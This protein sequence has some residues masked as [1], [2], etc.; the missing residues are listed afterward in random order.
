MFLA[1]LLINTFPHTVRKQESVHK[2][3]CCLISNEILNLIN[4]EC[5]DISTLT[6]VNL[7]AIICVW[8]TNRIFKL[9]FVLK[10]S[11]VMLSMG[12]GLLNVFRMVVHYH[13]GKY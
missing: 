9:L 5:K 11:V 6:P 12:L 3:I 1:F 4:G 8:S 2:M 13:S 7:M 10:G